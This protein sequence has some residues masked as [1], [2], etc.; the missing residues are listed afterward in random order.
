MLKRFGRSY[1]R[2]LRRSSRGQGL[3][4][5]VIALAILALITASVPSALLMITNYQFRWNERR[6]AENLTRNQI[7]YIMNSDYTTG[8]CGIAGRPACTTVPV[9]TGYWEI[10]VVA[11]PIQLN[12]STYPIITPLPNGQDQGVQQ[13]TV[14]IVH[15]EKDILTTKDFKGNRTEIWRPKI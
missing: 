6:T 14:T 1:L 15:N 10:M 3:V 12:P 13:V 11:Q 8:G 9:P 2:K 7:E 4:E 5:V